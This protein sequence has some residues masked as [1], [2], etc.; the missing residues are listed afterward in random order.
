MTQ[1]GENLQVTTDDERVTELMQAV[2]KAIEAATAEGM[3]LNQTLCLAAIA[4]T[5]FG[6]V[7]FGDAYIEH[8]CET[9]RMRRGE[10]LPENNLDEISH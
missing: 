7:A 3:D 8:L 10:P 1:F 2:A 4:V 6:R 5:E 9:I